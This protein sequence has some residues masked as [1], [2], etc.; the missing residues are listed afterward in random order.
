MS[1]CRRMLPVVLALF[2]TWSTAEHAASGQR[3]A[4]GLLM[5]AM[6]SPQLA[7]PHKTMGLAQRSF[8]DLVEEI[9][10]RLELALVIDATDSMSDCLEDM[11]QAVIKMT[12]DLHRYRGDQVAFQLV[13]YR[14]TGAGKGREVTYPLNIHDNGFVA[15]VAQLQQALASV[16]VSSGAP[17]FHELVDVGLHHAITKLNWTDDER[18]AR[19][20]ILFGDAPPYTSGYLDEETGASRQVETDQLVSLANIAGINVNC[21]L[22]TSREIESTAYQAALPETRQFMGTIST[23]TGGLLVDL[24]YDDIRRTIEATMA[25]P[26]VRYTP[27]KQITRDDVEAKRRELAAAAQASR[28]ARVAILPHMPLAEMSFDSN[29]PEVMVAAELRH[30]FR[31]A[32]N[33]DVKSA[34]SVRR[35]FIALQGRGLSETRF[36]RTLASGLNV[37]YVVWGQLKQLPGTAGTLEITSAIYSRAT[38]KPIVRRAEKSNVNVNPAQ[39]ITNQLAAGLIR[40]AATAGNVDQRLALAFRANDDTIS[41]VV[42]PVATLPETRDQI[43]VGFDL[44]EQSLAYQVG[45]PDGL[46]KLKQAEI[47]LRKATRRDPRNALAQHLLGNCYFNQARH[48]EQESD[49]KLAQQKARAFGGALQLAKRNRSSADQN[50]QIEIDADYELYLGDVTKAVESY[51]RL[52]GAEDP[53]ER[54]LHMALRAHWMLAGIYSGDFDVAAEIVNG[55]LARDHLLHILAEWPDSYQA[56]LIRRYM[57]WDEESAETKHNHLPLERSGVSRLIES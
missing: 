41:Q 1:V 33:A 3:T 10:A 32:E 43:L 14:D 28:R 15:D 40:T 54:N 7:P 26:R 46:E 11:K 29:R 52:T 19:W 24:S 45:E 12:A 20:I 55:N 2:V 44:L 50:T 8:L 13:V 56:D 5:E 17:Y 51:R 57:R 27:I 16:Q 25:K 48:F 21:V 9:D 31:L 35:M 30:K 37:D 39:N 6:F 34:S 36:L 49:E 47:Q 38:G 53:A 18:T 23:Q 4:P 22:C 42:R